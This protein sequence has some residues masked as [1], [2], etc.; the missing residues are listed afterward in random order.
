MYTIINGKWCHQD[1]EPLNS[2]DL[3]QLSTKINNMKPIAKL[4]HSDNLLSI[5]HIINS[6]SIT[7]QVINKLFN[8]EVSTIELINNKL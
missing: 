3:H 6:K 4:T 1:G 7:T 5:F 8:Q 2:V